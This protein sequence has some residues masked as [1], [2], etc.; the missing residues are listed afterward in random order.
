MKLFGPFVEETAVLVNYLEFQ[1]LN[2]LQELVW[3]LR[4]EF[5]DFGPF[6]ELI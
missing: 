4:D 6:L 5:L 3:A 2:F 1:V